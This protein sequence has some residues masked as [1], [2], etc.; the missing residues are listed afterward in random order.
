MT[1]LAADV[2]IVARGGG[3][4]KTRCAAALTP[5]QRARLVE[6]MLEDMLVALA[7]NAGWRVT[8]V[9][10]T[11]ELATRA[12]AH[13]V[14]CV[15]EA[16]ARTHTEAATT[17][18]FACAGERHLVLLPGDI[19]GV[20]AED[21]HQLLCALDT[22]DVAVAPSHDG[23]TSA[24]ALRRSADAWPV[25]YGGQSSARHYVSALKMGLR[26]VAQ[27]LP[28]VRYDI[29]TPADLV[30]L[31]RDGDG[32]SAQFVR[33][34]LGAQLANRLHQRERRARDSDPIL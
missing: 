34:C 11:P 18:R 33:S 25:Q 15:R 26:A 12:A 6:L 2:V 23:G 3:A 5:Q 17:G 9:T 20:R 4:A 1:A 24:L 16:S 27:H 30:R 22:C 31:A 14:R 7:A 28:S 29:D 32:E 13:G 8:L 19:P 21:V 10:C